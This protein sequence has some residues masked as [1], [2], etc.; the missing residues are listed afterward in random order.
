MITHHSHRRAALLCGG[1]ILMVVAGCQTGMNGGA[2]FG[3]RARGVPATQ[4]ALK[5]TESVILDVVAYYGY[6]IR[7]RWNEDK[8]SVH[9][10]IVGALY[11]MGPNGRGVFGD[12]I[13]HPKLYVHDRAARGTDREWTLVK[14]WKLNPLEMLPFRSKKPTVQGYGYLLPLDWADL[15]TDLSNREIRVVVSYERTDGLPPPRSSVKDLLVP[16]KGGT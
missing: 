5:N 11:L 7:W 12:G 6:P 15:N 16:A 14:E 1:C 9:G 4:E 3:G 10:L 2:P 8:T 13:I